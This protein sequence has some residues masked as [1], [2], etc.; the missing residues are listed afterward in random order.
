MKSP[1][2]SPSQTRTRARKRVR[3]HAHAA[4]ES[5]G[6]R[7]QQR[8]NKQNMRKLR[9]TGLIIRRVDGENASR[10]GQ[11]ATKRFRSGRPLLRLDNPL[12]SRH[13]LVFHSRFRRCRLIISASAAAAAV[14]KRC[15]VMTSRA[16]AHSRVTA[17]TKSSSTPSPASPSSDAR[18]QL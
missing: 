17:A 5:V 9:D 12:V 16:C 11:N 6:C 10:D 13:R 1:R 18:L 8:I 3:K 4:I 7:K 2:P 15:H 14:A